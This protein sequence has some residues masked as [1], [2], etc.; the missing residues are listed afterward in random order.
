MAQISIYVITAVIAL[1]GLFDFIKDEWE[2]R[3]SPTKDPVKKRKRVAQFIAVVG[4]IML[5]ILTWFHDRENTRNQLELRHRLARMTEIQRE[6]D[7]ASNAAAQARIGIRAGFE[8]LRLTS[9][10]DNS[11][12]RTRTTVLLESVRTDYERM[13]DRGIKETTAGTG[14]ELLGYY[15]LPGENATD[16]ITLPVV[17]E[18]IRADQDL[19]RVAC[20]FGAFAE[21]SDTKTEIF[22]FDAVERF[23][24]AAPARCARSGM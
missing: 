24:A 3:R 2:Q 23:C 21:L 17:V 6:M 10:S 16:T 18:I 11:E 12:V 13:L 20:A 1:S 14:V 19:N 4:S 7:R 5:A 8:T 15:G 22:D 9:R